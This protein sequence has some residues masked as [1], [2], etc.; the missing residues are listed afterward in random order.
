M[1]LILV[2]LLTVLGTLG[3]SAAMVGVS[4]GAAA[5]QDF[6]AG[7]SVALA[8]TFTTSLNAHDLDGV[9]ALFTEEDSGATVNAD[10]YAWEKFEIRLWAEQQVAANIYSDGYKYRATDH[11]ATWSADVY[12]DD[13]RGIGLEFVPVNNSIWV[14][15]GH[16]A[17]FTSMVSSPSDLELLGNFWRPGVSPERTGT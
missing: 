11:G 16:I 3:L 6:D 8:E 14:H 1:R 13:W 7:S 9:V 2:R 4:F 10:R 17:Q 12:R 15:N 5:S